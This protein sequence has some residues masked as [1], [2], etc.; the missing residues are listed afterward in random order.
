MPVASSRGGNSPENASQPQASQ[1]DPTAG[2][3]LSSRRPGRRGGS[4]AGTFRQPQERQRSP[5]ALGILRS[6][7]P[8]TRF[9]RTPERESATAPG[10][11]LPRMG[12]GSA[13]QGVQ[14]HA[15]VE[16]DAG[17][18]GLLVEDHE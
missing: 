18:Q 1:R 10:T 6:R 8:G 13:G 7:R 3:V 11:C 17:R 16:G 12:S 2:G 4:A 9:S 5:T 15:G 14:G